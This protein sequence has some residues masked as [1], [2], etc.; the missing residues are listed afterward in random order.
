MDLLVWMDASKHRVIRM[1]CTTARSIT[2]RKI[3]AGLYDSI[4]TRQ[5]N[6]VSERQIIIVG[7]L[8]V[9]IW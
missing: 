2:R 4:W 7:Y 5:R 9:F 8:S 6:W 3:A 1:L